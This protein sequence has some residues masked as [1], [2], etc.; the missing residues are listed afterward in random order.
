LIII[1]KSRGIPDF[2]PTLPAGRQAAGRR[3]WDD[4]NF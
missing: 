1:A 2:L 3:L 4:G